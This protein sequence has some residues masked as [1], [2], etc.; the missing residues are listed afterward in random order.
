MYLKRDSDIYFEK[1]SYNSQ[2]K[3]I[4]EKRF[5]YIFEKKRS[6]RVRRAKG[7]LIWRE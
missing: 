7:S 5:R 3:F 1:E 2:G 4:S 6:H